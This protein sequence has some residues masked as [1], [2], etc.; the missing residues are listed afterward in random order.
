MCSL[1]IA[2]ILVGGGISRRSKGQSQGHSIW[3]IIILYPT[4]AVF[5]SSLF[6]GFIGTVARELI[7]KLSGDAH[8]GFVIAALWLGEQSPWKA[9][10]LLG[11]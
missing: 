9:V 6:D 5:D 4:N 11:P 1:I 2:A 10:G 3:V 8:I 7:W